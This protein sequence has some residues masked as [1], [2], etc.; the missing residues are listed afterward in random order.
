MHLALFN[1]HRDYKSTALKRALKQTFVYFANTF[2]LNE[3]LNDLYQSK[4]R[5]HGICKKKKYVC[6][7]EVGAAIALLCTQV[8]YGSMGIVWELY[9]RIVKE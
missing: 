8:S 1:G 5:N 3:T 6:V 9:K 2:Q 4:Q 7:I